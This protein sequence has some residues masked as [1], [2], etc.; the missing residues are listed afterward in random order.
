M[1]P[2]GKYPQWDRQCSTCGRRAIMY[3]SSLDDTASC[4]ELRCVKLLANFLQLSQG[5]DVMKTALSYRDEFIK[6]EGSYAQ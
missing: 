1:K 2:K 4:E 3:G 6:G 5:I